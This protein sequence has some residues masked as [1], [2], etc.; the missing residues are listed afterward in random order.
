M[1]SEL[2]FFVMGV[3]MNLPR[4]AW[5]WLVA[6]EEGGS[7]GMMVGWFSETILGYGTWIRCGCGGIRYTAGGRGTELMGNGIYWGGEI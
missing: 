3:W 2:Y 4:M 7:I 5:A 1:V 6:E